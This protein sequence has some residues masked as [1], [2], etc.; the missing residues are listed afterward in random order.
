MT[1]SYTS[2]QVR[3]PFSCERPVWYPC[4]HNWGPELLQCNW[5]SNTGTSILFTS[6][7]PSSSEYSPHQQPKDARFEQPDNEQQLD[8]VDD[9]TASLESLAALALNEPDED[10][11]RE[12]ER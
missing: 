4:N 8:T 3:N 10:K 6:S 2:I 5:A 7:L 12:E 9:L 11:L 1:W